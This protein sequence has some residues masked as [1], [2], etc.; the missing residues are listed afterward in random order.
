MAQQR[1]HKDATA[2]KGPWVITL[3][4]VSAGPAMENLK[5]STVREKL[6]KV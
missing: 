1:G 2:E 4:A 5:N 3:D 6:Y